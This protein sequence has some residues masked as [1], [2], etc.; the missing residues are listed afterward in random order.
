M[1]DDA[2]AAAAIDERAAV[3]AT[4]ETAAFAVI[5]DAL[6]AAVTAGAACNLCGGFDATVLSRRS[7]SG[8][9]LR[10]I[11]CRCCG[12]VRSD[13]RPHDARR[14]YE[15]DYRR[16]YKRTF[17]PRAKHV[18]RAGKVALAKLE[19]IRP[20]LR[21]RTRVVDVG[22]GGGEFAY[23]MKT[24]GL[25]VLAIEPNRDYAGYA[26]REYG[27]MV[28]RGFVDEVALEAASCDLITIW[29]VLEHTEDPAD[30]LERL[31]RALRPTGLLVVEV[32]NV[33]ATCQSPGNTFHEA[34]LY[35]FNAATLAARAAKTGLQ[36]SASWLSA[37][38]GNS[39]AFL[40]PMPV[41]AP[42]AVGEQLAL[43]GNHD[44]IVAIRRNHTPAAHW[45]SAHPYRR[46]AARLTRLLTEGW[47]TLRPLDS[48]RRLD[49]LYA[50]ACRRP[51]PSRVDA[52]GRPLA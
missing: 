51:L 39:T 14:F 38:G 19:L 47:G 35:D 46:L 43:P 2:T 40:R 13:P 22:G 8:R 49:A 30:V 12:L 27:L 11:V 21:A 44:R 48:R 1:D 32:P 10:T 28:A 17:E 42:R 15:S 34:H 18:L 50:S 20:H 7:R 52:V 4:D 6:G 29:H 5:D 36:V 41:D 26:A 33:E 37:D 25:D 45:R 23:L 3:A 9:P 16:V 31:G 24:L